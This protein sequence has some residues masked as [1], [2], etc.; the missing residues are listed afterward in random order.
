ME[1]PHLATAVLPQ[2]AIRSD[3]DFV[4]PERDPGV[5]RRDDRVVRLGPRLCDPSVPVDVQHGG[6]PFLRRFFVAG[7]VEYPRVDPTELA[8]LPEEDAV[9]PQAT[10]FGL[11]WRW[12]LDRSSTR[13]LVGWRTTVGTAQMEQRLGNVERRVDR[14][15]QILPTLATRDDLKAAVAPLATKVELRAAI[16]ESEQRMRAHVADAVSA[17]EQRMRTHFDVVAES[18]RDDIRLVAEAIAALS[19]RQR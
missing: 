19:E 3:A 1:R 10:V 17:S 4:A 11:R 14:I 12:S 2:A 5:L 8:G 13:A 6:T 18:L 15:E 7:L 16:G 9:A